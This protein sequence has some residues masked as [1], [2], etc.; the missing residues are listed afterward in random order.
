MATPRLITA[1]IQE[2]AAT[3]S[4]VINAVS[5]TGLVTR[6]G[7]V[8]QTVDEQLTKIANG[9]LTVEIIDPG[10]AIWTFINDSLETSN[11]MIPPW[12]FLQVAGVTK[13]CG[14]ID[15]ARAVQHYDGDKRSVELGVVSWSSELDGVYLGSPTALPWQQDWVYTAGQQVLNGSNLY[16]CTQGGTSSSTGVGPLGILCTASSP[17]VDGT[18]QWAYVPPAWQRPLP[19]GAANSSSAVSQLG[20]SFNPLYTVNG[21]YEN[22]VLF[23]L[24]SAWLYTGAL[25]QYQT[26]PVFGYLLS[27]QQT[28]WQAWALSTV[29]H[30]TLVKN[31]TLPDGEIWHYDGANWTLVQA[32]TIGNDPL[33]ALPSSQFPV[34]SIILAN[35]TNYQSTSGNTWVTG[36]SISWT[37]PVGYWKV[38]QINNPEKTDL[39]TSSSTGG[40]SVVLSSIP[41]PT[42]PG[43]GNFVAGCG[44]GGGVN[45]NAGMTW[46]ATIEIAVPTAQDLEYWTVLQAVPA[47]P[48]TP[49]YQLVLGNSSGIGNVNGIV[50][51]DKLQLVQSDTSGSWTVAGVDPI[52]CAVNTVEPVTNVALGAHV[53]WDQQSSLEYV[54]EDAVKMLKLVVAPYSVDTSQFSKPSTAIPMFAWLPLRPVA[55]ADLF[56][57]GDIEPTLA[58]T[59]KLMTGANW[60]TWASGSPVAMPSYSWTG[61][62][63]AGWTTAS[64]VYAPNADWTCQLTGAPASL[65]PYEAFT[66]NPWMRLRNRAYSDVGYYRENN[67]LIEVQ[68]GASTYFVNGA[69]V[70]SMTTPNTYQFEQNGTVYLSTGSGANFTLWTPLGANVVGSFPCYDYTVMKKYLFVGGNALNGRNYTTVTVYPWTGSAWGSP[71]TP[72]TWPGALGYVQSAVPFIQS[73]YA[74]GSILGYATDEWNTTTSGNSWPGASTSGDV[75]QLVSATGTLIATSAAV[76]PALV[77]GTLVTTPYATYLVGGIA[78]ALITYSGGVISFTTMFLIDECTALFANTLCAIDQNRIA[79]FGR[80]DVGSG[81]SAA[82]STWL[83]VIQ[84]NL[85]N[86]LDQ[87]ILWSELIAQGVPAT[88]GCV[89][90]PSMA[91]RIVGH[92]G[93]SLFQIAQERPLTIERWVPGG[94]TASEALEHIAQVFAAVIVP[95]A[96]G[97]YH[98]ISRTGTPAPVNINAL[99][100]KVDTTWGWKD[101]ASIVRVSSQDGTYHYDAYAQNAAGVYQEGGRLLEVANQ[102][103]IFSLSGAAG[104]AQASVGWYGVARSGSSQAWFYPDPTSAAPW[105]ALIGFQRITVNGGTQAYRVMSFSINYVAGTC[106]VELLTD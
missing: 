87:S 58:G 27:S 35:G 3:A 102:P 31:Y 106:D 9:E 12:L 85:S 91:G 23:P 45:G 10:D 46:S 11:G 66:V 63:D 92:Y 15:P 96:I 14:L 36:A 39:P 42:L 30:G 76:P 70:Q 83:F 33:L 22:C 32:W 49:C 60:T 28:G 98:V 61:T 53:F 93:G 67:G 26:A 79:I 84:S 19:Q 77:G 52:V 97:T 38:M 57:I 80:Q 44:I 8:V 65:M 16:L 4:S 68:E 55:G 62:P 71:G 41:W 21:Q 50:P 73:G 5:L 99:Q 54:N 69:F 95:D 86:T 17:Y 51:G 25:L 43:N 88:L 6:V 105:E 1:I 81:S 90:D 100:T 18:C 56:A 47:N 89:R 103:M 7:R 29:G 75:L 24:P 82:T 104:M 40:L 101:F 59:L 34:G 78:M 2:N 64:S 37:P 48:A 72:W 94:M 13:F 20:Y 74:A